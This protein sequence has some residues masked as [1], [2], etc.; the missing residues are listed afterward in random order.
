MARHES[1]ARH[2]HRLHSLWHWPWE[3]SRGRPPQGRRR[4]GSST[5]RSTHCDELPDGP[6]SFNG[7]L[8]GHD[9]GS[10]PRAHPVAPDATG[11]RPA[12]IPERV[13]DPGFQGN[14]E[15]EP[16]NVFFDGT[17]SDKH[18]Q[19]LGRGQGSKVGVVRFLLKN[20]WDL[21]PG[22]FNQKF[23]YNLSSP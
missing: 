3:I 10:S 5:L 17:L 6:T 19:L 12:S 16:G 14:L 18:P 9:T 15:G 2:S 21:A 23:L 8:R 13:S 1:D 7:S 11:A 22:Q 20:S 4:G